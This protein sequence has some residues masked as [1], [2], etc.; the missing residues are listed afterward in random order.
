MTGNR[1]APS[2]LPEGVLLLPVCLPT[3]LPFYLFPFLPACLPFSLFAW[4]SFSDASRHA[5]AAAGSSTSC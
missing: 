4:P 3:F 1:K 5:A 2:M